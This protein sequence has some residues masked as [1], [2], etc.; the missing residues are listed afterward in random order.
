MTG[1]EQ[2]K[3][4][5]RYQRDEQDQARQAARSLDFVPSVVGATGISEPLG[6]EEEGG[7]EKG[8]GR[9]KGSRREQQ[10]G[11]HLQQVQA[12]SMGTAI[13]WMGRWMEEVW[14]NRA[15][16]SVDCGFEWVWR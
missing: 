5:G 16:I 7:R 10:S 8:E 6:G 9:G 1:G 4:W 14:M 3:D 2:R 15:H 12:I 13:G 11:D